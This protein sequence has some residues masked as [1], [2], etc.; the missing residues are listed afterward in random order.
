MLW[1]VK[2]WHVSS[3]G[4]FIQHLVTCLLIAE[5]DRDLYHLVMVFYCVPNEIQLLLRIL[6]YLWRVFLL[7]FW[8]RDAPLV[9]N[10]ISESIVLKDELTRFTLHCLMPMRGEKSKA[11]LALFDGFQEL[12]LSNY[13]IWCLFVFSFFLNYFMKSSVVYAASLCTFV[14]F[15]TM[16]WPNIRFHKSLQNFQKPL[17]ILWP[18]IERKRSEQYLIKI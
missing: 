5:A 7:C 14:S 16:I 4:K 6:C 3:C 10:P 13:C 1:L 15:D 11:I 8:F 2:I 9:G 17:D 12:H 18:Q